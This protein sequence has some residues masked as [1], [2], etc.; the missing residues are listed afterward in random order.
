V[1]IVPGYRINPT[2]SPDQENALNKI[3]PK[4][5]ADAKEG[6]AILVLAGAAGTGKTT[7]MR[8]VIDE[9]NKAG[10]TTYLAAPTGKAASRL[11]QTTGLKTSTVHSLLYAAP[12]TMGQCRA[13]RSGNSSTCSTGC[14]G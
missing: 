3:L 14:S 10:I 6:R 2:L 5:K 4:L 11:K 1:Q 7:L 12:T 13:E 9:L 8:V